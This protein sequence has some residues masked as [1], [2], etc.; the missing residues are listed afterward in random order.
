M[1][2]VNG[3]R[4][5]DSLRF[6]EVAERIFWQQYKKELLKLFMDSKPKK[7]MHFRSGT[8]IMVGTKQ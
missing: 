5:D 3:G 2:K 1:K 7:L 6:I 4:P 8:K